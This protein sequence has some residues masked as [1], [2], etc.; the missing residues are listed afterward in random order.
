MRPSNF[1]SN[2]HNNNPKRKRQRLAVWLAS[3][4]LLSLILT[5]TGCEQL[6]ERFPSFPDLERLRPSPK[7]SPPPTPAQSK[8]TA[9]IETAIYQQ[10]NQVREQDG[11]S[12]L[13]NNDRLAAVA[14]KYSRQMAEK[15][16]FSH[17]GADGSTLVDRVRA[18]QISY[19][20][21]G[22]NLFKGTNV[23]QPAPS[24]VD[25]WL[26]SPGHR[27]NILRSVFAETGIGVWKKGDTYYITQLFLRK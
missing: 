13:K 4:G 10:I 6:R 14:R 18:G 23:P 22:E 21:V 15:N 19:Y 17:T 7:P 24:A 11:L 8:T 25:G 2:R 20:V 26:K 12:K 9:Q 27:E 3:L 16:F 1:Q 5:T